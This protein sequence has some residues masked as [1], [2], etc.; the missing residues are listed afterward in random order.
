MTGQRYEGGG[1]YRFWIAKRL[2]LATA[3]FQGMPYPVG[4]S[5]GRDIQFNPAVSADVQVTATLYVN[6]NAS[7]VRSLSYSGKASAAGIFGAAQGMKSFPLDAPGEY[8]AHILATYTDSEGHLWVSAMRH[9]GV[10]YPEP[11]PVVARGKKFLV[12]TKYVDRGET[13]FEGYVEPDGTQHLAHITFPY[14]NGDVLLVA[15]EGQGANKI[16][17]V[18]TYQMQGDVAAVGH[19]VERRRDHEPPAS[20]RRT[21][22]RRICTPSTSPT[23]STT[24][25]P[26]RAPGSWAGSSS[27]R[28]PCARPTGRSARTVSAG[29]SAPPRTATRPATST[30]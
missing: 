12:G 10:V 4:S 25:A 30:A 15:A 19:E 14:L 20:R 28:A 26:R 9:A 6:S 29:R 21:A 23:S 18:L 3:T 22:T 11:S 16:E 27:A 17:P 2:T 13:R 5:Y 1:T 8:H 24:T 7:T